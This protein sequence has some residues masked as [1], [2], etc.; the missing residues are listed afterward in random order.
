[1]RDGRGGEGGGGERGKGER[2]GEEEVRDG[3]GGGDWTRIGDIHFS[4]YITNSDLS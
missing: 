1:M 2:K 3:R 4:Q